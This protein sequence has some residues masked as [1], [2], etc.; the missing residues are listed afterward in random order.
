MSGHEEKTDAVEP[1]DPTTVREHFK[2]IYFETIDFIHNALKERTTP[3]EINKLRKL[4]EG[5]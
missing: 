5:V 4:L 2:A 1:Y 3:T